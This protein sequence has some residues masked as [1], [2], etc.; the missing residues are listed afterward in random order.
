MRSART[1]A[2]IAYLFFFFARSLPRRRLRRRRRGSHALETAT[3]WGRRRRALARARAV[4]RLDAH[5]CA[6]S[7]SRPLQNTGVAQRINKER[8]ARKAAGRTHGESGRASKRGRVSRPRS[9]PGA[10]VVLGVGGENAAVAPLRYCGGP[11]TTHTRVAQKRDTDRP[12]KKKKKQ[13]KKTGT[14]SRDAARPRERMLLIPLCQLFFCA[15][16]RSTINAAE[17]AHTTIRCT[18]A[19]AC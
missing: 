12:A 14:L 4:A 9:M 7:G 8:K 17:E 16:T 19:S 5:N 6:R 1:V 2:R 15:A 13:N 18:H 10:R 3:K 11:R